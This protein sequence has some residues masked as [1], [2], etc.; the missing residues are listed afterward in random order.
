MNKQIR[1]YQKLV[2]NKYHI[3]NSLF[4]QLPYE[5]MTNIGTLIPILLMDG[6]DGFEKGKNPLE[7]KGLKQTQ[8]MV[9]GQAYHMG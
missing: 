7:V 4:M 9:A 5:K 3:Y 1:Q 6:E 8:G 2:L